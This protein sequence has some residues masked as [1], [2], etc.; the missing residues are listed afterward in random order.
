MIQSLDKLYP[1]LEKD[2]G[3]FLLRQ[4]RFLHGP[5]VMLGAYLDESSTGSHEPALCVAGVLFD[6]SV[7]EEMDSQWKSELDQFGIS[8]FHIKDYAHSFGEFKGKDPVQ[9]NDLFKRLVQLICKYSLGSVAIFNRNTPE[10]DPFFNNKQSFSPYTACGYYCME[11]IVQ[12][13]RQR[14]QKVSFAIEKGH[15]KMGELNRLIEKRQ[16]VDGWPG[17]ASA[18][19]Q[20]K[21]LRLLQAADVFAYEY[22]KRI[23]DYNVRLRKS[24]QVLITEGQGNH[25]W[26]ILTPHILDQ[27]SRLIATEPNR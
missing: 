6:E 12:Q 14:N 20:G 8:V 11:M 7:L 10:F 21:E 16:S 3:A 1:A 22:A 2:V 25:S 9:A 19:F 17:M 24:F 27:I 4:L 15:E 23:K 18:G 13:A 5:Y 26:S